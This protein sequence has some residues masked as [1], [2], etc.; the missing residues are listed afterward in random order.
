M[1]HSVQTRVKYKIML[2]FL[3]LSGT[4]SAREKRTLNRKITH[5]IEFLVTFRDPPFFKG[6]QTQ[7]NNTLYGVFNHSP[8]PS[9]AR[10][11][12]MLDK[13]IFGCK[14]VPAL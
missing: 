8:G 5:Y 12:R 9:S 10:E 1:L 2:I 6:K 4:P 13:H 7:K 3:S 14:K 11:K